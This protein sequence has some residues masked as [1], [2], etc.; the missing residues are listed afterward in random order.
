MCNQSGLLLVAVGMS[1]L[2]VAATIAFLALPM[3]S[4]LSVRAFPP[5]IPPLRG[6]GKRPR[7]HTPFFPPS[8]NHRP[9]QVVQGSLVIY[10][11]LSTAIVLQFFAQQVGFVDPSSGSLYST[12]IPYASSTTD[13]QLAGA[14]YCFNF[15]AGRGAVNACNALVPVVNAAQQVG[16]FFFFFFFFFLRPDL[17][18]LSPR[19]PMPPHAL[20][21]LICLQ[22]RRASGWAPSLFLRCCVRL[23]ARLRRRARAQR[24][25]SRPAPCRRRRCWR[26]RSPSY[27]SA[28][29]RVCAAPQHFRWLSR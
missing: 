9:F 19:G 8:L 3:Y 18:A 4:M 24:Q 23:W 1:V 26:R 7:S 15:A 22:A 13:I 27:S 17:G 2:S 14:S 10:P 21:H 28:R 6:V 5:P 12:P 20:P 25:P 29:L 11:P 16:A